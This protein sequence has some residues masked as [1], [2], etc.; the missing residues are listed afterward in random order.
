MIFMKRRDSAI[1]IYQHLD[2]VPLA[3]NIK[4]LQSN[5]MKRLIEGEQPEPIKMHYPLNYNHSINNSRLVIPFYRSKIGTSLL[6]Y[7]GFK[8]C[9]DIPFVLKSKPFKI[10]A[11]DFQKNT[12]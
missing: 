11:K 9:N 5:F 4:L 10:F 8:L 3:S 2:I 1:P 7:Q 6:H 12:F